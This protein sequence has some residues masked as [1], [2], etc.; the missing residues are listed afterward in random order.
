[1]YEHYHLIYKPPISAGSNISFLI[2]FGI[3]V[4]WIFSLAYIL[5]R[6]LRRSNAWELL[7]MPR[8]Q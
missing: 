4:I 5:R 6:F 3:Y 1:M 8:I 2:I 7:N